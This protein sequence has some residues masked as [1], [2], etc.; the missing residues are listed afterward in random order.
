M[1]NASNERK[2]KLYQVEQKPFASKEKNIR[3]LIQKSSG[4]RLPVTWPWLNASLGTQTAQA[5][6]MSQPGS[7]AAQTMPSA[8]SQLLL[9]QRANAAA[10]TAAQRRRFVFNTE[11]TA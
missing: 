11:K 4:Y 1:N 7:A 6:M 9:A 8:A 10:H 3:N 5:Q 2:K